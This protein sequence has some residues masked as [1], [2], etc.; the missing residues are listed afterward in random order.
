MAARMEMLDELMAPIEDAA[1]EE[2]EITIRDE[3][4]QD[5]EPL[6]VARDPKL[7][8]EDDVECHRCSHIPFRSWCRWCVM[9][10]GRGDPHLTSAGSSI[11]IVGLDYFYID[12]ESVKKRE[13]LDYEKD[14]AGEAALDEERAAGNLVKCMVVRCASTKCIFGHVIPR[15]GADEEDFSANLV[16][17]DVSWLGHTEL[18][19]KGDNEPALQ[20]LI[21]R[22][23]EVIRVKAGHVDK[24]N[25]ERPPAYDS[26][27][28]GAIEVGVMLIRG[29]FR[30]LRLCLE[31]RI[32]KRIPA[33]HAMIPWLLEH[34]CFL[35][36]IKSRGSD[37]HTAWARARGRPFGQKMLGIGE[38]VLYKLPSKGPQ[39]AANMSAR[40]ADAVF[41]GY[42]RSSNTY[43]LCTAEGLVTARS[44]NRL[45]QPN[46][47]S[48]EALAAIKATPWSERERSAPEVRFQDPAAHREEPV[49]VAIPA[50]TRRFRINDADLRRHGFTDGCPQ[51][52][53]TQRY[54]KAKSGLQHHERCRER[55]IKAIE[56]SDDG[57]ARIEAHKAREDRY[58]AEH[59]ERSEAVPGNIP[60]AP[61]GEGV[62]W[63]KR[64]FVLN[65][66]NLFNVNR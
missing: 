63:R 37:G 66:M 48:A 3:E 46:R 8:S 62:T 51:C 55:I 57:K 41:L 10:R 23:L 32:G 49:E 22:S 1:E 34:T 53:H 4:E 47:W 43:R 42:S 29:L 17:E 60:S 15:K 61:G 50:P 9:G 30:T 19:L 5:A 64:K 25:T 11:P 40:W 7:P 59:L 45:P 20:A 18:M 31:A 27:S 6:K 56:E 28:N 54:G 2:G 33:G 36:N 52:A 38:S 12:D 13:E 24:I 58:L 65:M 35:L 21:A 26:Q 44:L 14:A 39:S 16:V